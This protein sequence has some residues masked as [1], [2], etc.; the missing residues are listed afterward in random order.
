MKLHDY[1]YTDTLNEKKKK[2]RE[3]VEG[4]KWNK[5]YP[6][7]S[8]T[9]CESSVFMKENSG[10]YIYIIYIYIYV[11]IKLVRSGS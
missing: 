5:E 8:P 2:I 7:L 3:Y 6:I 9:I 11:C 1:H 10:I 4:V